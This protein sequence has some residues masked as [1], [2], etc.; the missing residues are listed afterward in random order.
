MLAATYALPWL[1]FRTKW[2]VRYLTS[3]KHGKVP[4][5]VIRTVRFLNYVAS[6]SKVGEVGRAGLSLASPL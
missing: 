1:S 6:S 4:R 3:D 2:L 5:G